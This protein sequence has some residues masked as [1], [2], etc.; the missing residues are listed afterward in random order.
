[1]S[2]PS[3]PILL[4]LVLLQAALPAAAQSRGQLLYDNHCRT[5]HTTQMHWRD[6]RQVTDWAS[7]KAQVRRWQGTAQLGWSEEDIDDVARH[8]NDT[9]YRLPGPGKVAEAPTPQP[10]RR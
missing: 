8:L 9:I 6:K 3:V 7:L 4:A 2:T 1:M 10:P 5:C